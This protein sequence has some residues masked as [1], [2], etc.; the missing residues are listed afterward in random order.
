M[1]AFVIWMA[2]WLLNNTLKM[3]LLNNGNFWISTLPEDSNKDFCENCNYHGNNGKRKQTYCQNLRKKTLPNGS[4]TLDHQHDLKSPK[5]AGV[6][7]TEY[8][9]VSKGLLHCMGN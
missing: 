6:G 9:P 3:L 2:G 7:T 8:V 1:I 4:C 5:V